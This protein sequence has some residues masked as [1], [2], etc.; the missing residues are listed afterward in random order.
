[1]SSVPDVLSE[2]DRIRTVMIELKK[3]KK[4]FSVL[5]LQGSSAAAYPQALSMY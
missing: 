1:M 3:K 2:S 4:T 5:L